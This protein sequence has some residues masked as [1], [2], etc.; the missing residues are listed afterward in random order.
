ME[1]MMTSLGFYWRKRL[2]L[3]G[4]DV[5][6]PGAGALSDNGVIQAFVVTNL[7]TPGQNRVLV[8]DDEGT[9][10]VAGAERPDAGYWKDLCMNHQG[11]RIAVLSPLTNE[12]LITSD[13]GNVFMSSVL[14]SAGF[15]SAD[16]FSSADMKYMVVTGTPVCMV[17]VDGGA[18][19]NARVSTAVKCVIDESGGLVYIDENGSVRRGTV[20]TLGEA[21]GP[22]DEVPPE[23]GPPDFVQRHLDVGCSSGKPSKPTTCPSGFTA[24]NSVQKNSASDLQ[25]EMRKF[26]RPGD[27]CAGLADCS[28]PN[29]QIQAGCGALLVDYYG[30]ICERTAAQRSS[31]ASDLIFAGPV[32]PGVLAVRGQEVLFATRD[33]T[34]AFR[35]FVD[36][37]PSTAWEPVPIGLS[38]PVFAAFDSEGIPVLG[39]TTTVV[40][41][42][43]KPEPNVLGLVALLTNMSGLWMTWSPKFLYED[44]DPSVCLNLKTECPASHTRQTFIGLCGSQANCPPNTTLND[45]IQKYYREDVAPAIKDKW[46]EGDSCTDY[47]TCGLGKAPSVQG[48][49]CHVDYHVTTCTDDDYPTDARMQLACALGMEWD[50]PGSTA[51][52]DQQLCNSSQVRNGSDFVA[53]CLAWQGDKANCGEAT[54]TGTI[55]LAC[56]PHIK[57]FCQNNMAAPE[58]VAWCNKNQGDASLGAWCDPAMIKYCDTAEGKKSVACGCI[59]SKLF[60]ASCLDPACTNKNAYQTAKMRE[61]RR[62]VPC[63]D[64]CLA[65][66]NAQN[67]TGSIVIDGPQFNLQCGNSLPEGARLKTWYS[68]NAQG[69]C[70][71]TPVGQKGQY[72]DDPTCTK[73]AEPEGLNWTLWGPIIGLLILGVILAIVLPLVL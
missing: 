10:F 67:E 62:S 13:K 43:G 42:P 1:A 66:L 19:W 9:T 30:L 61:E 65:I 2:E 32:W 56:A 54:T 23:E 31:A 24:M 17:S 48:P 21:E 68:K 38:E 3:M 15:K 73:P 59:A 70:I 53:Q 34:P 69:E 50:K 46:R 39:T 18:T 45:H 27:L 4:G 49:V 72:P 40:F 47:L 37:V 58:C 20:E 36:N 26:Y 44:C 35:V 64:V 63:P 33:A 14:G 41:R 6:L 60:N 29:L 7:S 57:D 22:P 52:C 11:T 8:S 71:V 51:C 16:L 28:G 12:V 25:T 55:G 5:L